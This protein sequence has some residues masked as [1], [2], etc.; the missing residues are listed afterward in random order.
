M[1]LQSRII[2]KF[3]FRVPT[4]GQ[5]AENPV[6]RELRASDNSVHFVE[7]HFTIS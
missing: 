4:T 1:C 2:G 5:V 7:S 6:F 3:R